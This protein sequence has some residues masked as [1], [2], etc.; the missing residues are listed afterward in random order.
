MQELENIGKAFV[1]TLIGTG[2][3]ILISML[4]V[5]VLFRLISVIS[6]KAEHR[7]TEGERK[8][9]KT[10]TRT[11]IYTARVTLKTAVVLLLVGY[12]G[13]DMSGIAALIASLGVGVGLAVN[14]AL[15]NLAGGVL[16]IVT[17]PFKIDD[18][19]EAE[20]KSGTVEDI[21]IT[22]TKI[23]TPDN[24]VVYIPNG[25]LSADVIVNYSEKKTRRV[26]LLFPLDYTADTELV[27]SEILKIIAEN[28]AVL[29]EPEPFVRASA[30]DADGAFITVRIWCENEEYWNVYFDIFES[31]K[32]LLDALKISV[33]HRKIDINVNNY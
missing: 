10:L 25:K 23:R 24:K 30:R 11:L 18:F 6:R 32:A 26:D 17:R 3:K 9:D 14:G 29:Q 31:V 16:L 20:G 12:I 22:M 7:L 15:S 13:V 1:S 33:P 2:V 4:V 8:L 27:K 21:H 5:F 28:S 19:I